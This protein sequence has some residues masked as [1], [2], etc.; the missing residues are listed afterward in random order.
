[1]VMDGKSG[2]QKIYLSMLPA[3][4]VQQNDSGY[5]F[6]SGAVV[7]RNQPANAMKQDDI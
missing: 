5:T 1:M 4:G 6:V 7:S 2:R 3:G